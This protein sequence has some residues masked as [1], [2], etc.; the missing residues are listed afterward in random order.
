M[1]CLQQE[2]CRKVGGG[3]NNHRLYYN[4]LISGLTEFFWL[5][6]LNFN[7]SNSNRLQLPGR[8]LE[9]IGPA[10]NLERR[11]VQWH[12]RSSNYD[13]KQNQTSIRLYSA[14]HFDSLCNYPCLDS[15]RNK[16]CFLLRALYW[17]DPSCY[18]SRTFC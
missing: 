3:N 6:F 18:H 5:L 15:C 13:K 1:P 12:D 10:A 9:N 8:Q 17:F 14:F 7:M 4:Q 11:C 2:I 16:Y